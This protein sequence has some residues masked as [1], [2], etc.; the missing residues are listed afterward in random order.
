MGAGYREPRAPGFTYEFIAGRMKRINRSIHL[1]QLSE[2]NET[3]EEDYNWDFELYRDSLPH[4]LDAD[5]FPN[6]EDDPSAMADNLTLWVLGECGTSP[7]E[8][9]LAAP[10]RETRSFRPAAT[11]TSSI[12]PGFDSTRRKSRDNNCLRWVPFSSGRSL[13]INLWMLRNSNLIEDP[14]NCPKFAS[15]WER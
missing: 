15:F 12:R 5:K 13:S 6:P 9:H 10:T 7:C 3:P 1:F 11:S 8:L 4:E 14:P 2:E